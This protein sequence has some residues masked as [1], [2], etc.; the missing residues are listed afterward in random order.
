MD[1]DKTQTTNEQDNSSQEE[2][3]PFIDQMTDLAA[4]AAGMLTESALKAVAKKAKK[5][6]AKRMPTRVKK[7]AKA[8]A[9][10]AKAPKKTAKKKSPREEDRH[11][12][13]EEG[14]EEVRS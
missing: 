2:K 10:A 13:N 4:K 14:C 7:A 11:K 5:A 9:Q 1:T 8:A 12:I 3:K 6:V